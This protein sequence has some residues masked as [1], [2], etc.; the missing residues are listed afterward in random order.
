MNQ[1]PTSEEPLVGEVRFRVPL[2]F[3]IPAIALIVIAV[4][5]ISFS[6]VLL[7][8][9]HEAATILAVVMAANLLGACA[10][11]ALK[12]RLSMTTWLELL[13][14][15]AYPILIGVV[16]AATGIGDTHSVAAAG[17]NEEPAPAGDGLTVT[18]AA[19]SFDTDQISVPA[20]EETSIHFVNA[21]N[22]QHNISVYE[23][24][25]DGLVLENAIFEGEIIDGDQETDYD[26]KAP[27][28]GDYY[29]QCD[30]HPNMNGDF[31][32][33]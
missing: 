14:I 26:F 29:F 12:P 27:P 22:Q 31:T 18:A 11:A 6:R 30:V 33:E 7:A 20:E 32:A 9:P 3:A 21:D 1:H 13:A 4:L 25:D 28:A 24:P 15:V 10:Y 8:V 19:M 23:N 2:P 16:I 5:A 17:G